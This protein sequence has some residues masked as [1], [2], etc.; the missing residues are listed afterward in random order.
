MDA[1]WRLETGR[2]EPK[3]D[4]PGIFIRGDQALGYARTLRDLLKGIEQRAAELSET[5]IAAWMRVQALADL[6]ESCR[7]L[8]VSE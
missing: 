6:L 3:G 4:W 2:F 5:E 8:R 1:D 7:A